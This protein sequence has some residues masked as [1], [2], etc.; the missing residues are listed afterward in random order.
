MRLVYIYHTCTHTQR[1]PIVVWEPSGKYKREL[2]SRSAEESRHGGLSLPNTST[3]LSLSPP[4]VRPS[5]LASFLSSSSTSTKSPRA[6]ARARTLNVVV[7]G[8]NSSLTCLSLPYCV[9]AHHPRV[10]RESCT[11]DGERERESRVY[12]KIKKKAARVPGC[13]HHTGSLY[14]RFQLSSSP[15]CAVRRQYGPQPDERGE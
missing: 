2:V 9:A 15:V 1:T 10:C 12:D 6:V 3:H 14:Y 11:R 4:S 5:S 13:Y 7:V 8:G